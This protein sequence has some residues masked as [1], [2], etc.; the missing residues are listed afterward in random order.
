MSG[1]RE[2]ARPEIAALVA[3]IPATRSESILMDSNESWQDMHGN[4]R[5]LNRYPA[6]L[7]LAS[8]RLAPRYGVRPDQILLTRGSDDAI[9]ALSRVFCRAGQD[10]VQVTPPTFHMYSLSA[11]IQGDA[12]L[13]TPRTLPDFAFD[14]GQVL[15]DWRPAVK[16][17]YI[18]TPNNPTGNE[19]PAAD[20]QRLCR[21]LAGRSLVVVDEAYAE[22][23]STPSAA[24]YLDEYPNLV[25]LR[26]LSKAW[27][28]AGERCGVLLADPDV[29]HLVRQVL[30]PY[31]MA[32]SSLEAALRTLEPSA[33]RAMQARVE[34]VVHERTRLAEAIA[35]LP[36]VRRVYPSAANFLLA[37]F[38]DAAGLQQALSAAGLRVRPLKQP[39][40]QDCLRITIGSRAENDRLLALLRELEMAHA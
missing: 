11:R 31:P 3:Y 4:S 33:E 2:L 21:A 30:P 34:H 17:L 12:V 16:L 24:H 27:A 23:S 25:V 14:I 40:L 6:P 26:T 37:R 28:L 1:V 29:I 13:E 39:G 7:T 5:G 35:K 15:E 8:A 19:T 22:F 9:D 36:G 18:C 38:T 32:V 20:I 10:A